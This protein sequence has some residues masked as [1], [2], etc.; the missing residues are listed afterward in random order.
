MR[1]VLAK[2]VAVTA[3]FTKTSALLNA[4]ETSTHF[5]LQNDRL[6]VSVAKANGQVVRLFLDAQDLL[7]PVSGNSGKGPY[8]DCNCISSGFWTPGGTAKFQLFKGTDSTGTSYG[9]VVMGDTYAATNQTLYQ[10]WFLRDGETGLHVFTRVAYYNKE[11][12]FLQGLGELRTLF[13]PNTKLWTHFSGSDGNWSPMP[14]SASLSS[15]VTVQDA[16]SY[17]GTTPG[18]PFY[19]QYS[20]YFTKYS[21][22]EVWRDHDV[23]GEYADGSNSVDGNTYGAWL[24][25]NTHE[26]YYGGP[27]HS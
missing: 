12:Q 22:S 14:A 1:F 6:S 16:T 25:H 8:L 3:I 11:R 19:K 21:F 7:G 10:Y 23:H 2:L 18:D 20:E 4:T 5:I 24:V 13:R 27:L 15:A 9:G 26:T 17:L